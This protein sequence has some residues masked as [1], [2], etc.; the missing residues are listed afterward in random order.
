MAKPRKEVEGY[1]GSCDIY[2][3]VNKSGNRKFKLVQRPITSEPLDT[4]AIDIVGPLPKGKGCTHFIL[5]VG[6]TRAGL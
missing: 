2:L 5:T 4:I 1:V 3:H 6:A